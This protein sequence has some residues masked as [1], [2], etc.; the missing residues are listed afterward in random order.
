VSMVSS[1]ASTASEY[2]GFGCD[3][4]QSQRVKGFA[5]ASQRTKAAAE[6]AF[7]QADPKSTIIR[8]SIMFGPGDS[9]FTVSLDSRGSLPICPTGDD[10]F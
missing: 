3:W 2:C 7:L 1:K 9:F 10:Q 6:E 5:N 4:N 8:P